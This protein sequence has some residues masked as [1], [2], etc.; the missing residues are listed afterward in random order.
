MEKREITPFKWMGQTVEQEHV[1]RYID[2]ENPVGEIIGMKCFGKRGVTVT[3]VYCTVT[4]VYCMEQ[5]FICESDGSVRR[6]GE[7]VQV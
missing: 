7:E 3:D 2:R 4:D 1:L 6:L 5:T